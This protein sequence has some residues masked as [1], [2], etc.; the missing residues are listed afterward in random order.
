MS[1][2]VL[3][4]MNFAFGLT[5]FVVYAHL[6]RKGT[7]KQFN[8]IY[9]MKSMVGLIWSIVYGFVVASM[10]TPEYIY[11][12]RI[13]IRTAISLTLAMLVACAITSRRRQQNEP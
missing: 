12:D 7:R 6:V 3:A 2:I 10:I 8:W 11:V 4:T 5:V 9:A 13:V 1:D